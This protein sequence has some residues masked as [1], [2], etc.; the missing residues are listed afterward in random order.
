MDDDFQFP[1]LISI[2]MRGSNFCH[3]FWLFQCLSLSDAPTLADQ[4]KW[5]KKH[6]Q[7]YKNNE[8]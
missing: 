6:T 5:K 1:V 8:N 7:K 2:L 3:Q 4:T